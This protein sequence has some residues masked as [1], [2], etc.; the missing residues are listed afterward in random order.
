MNKILVFIVLILAMML[1]FW[2]E[3][4]L[5]HSQRLK[6]NIA[7]AVPAKITKISLII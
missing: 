7:Y 6:R 5:S 4:K 2:K 1:I 3:S